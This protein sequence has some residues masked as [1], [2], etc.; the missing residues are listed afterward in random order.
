MERTAIIHFT[1]DGRAEPQGRPRATKMGNNIKLY[2]PPKSKAYK[3]VVGLIAQS[4]MSRNQLEPYTGALK[5]TLGFCFKP[6]KSYTQKRLKS[7]QDGTELYTKKSDI[8]N[9]AKAVTDGMNQ[10]TYHD[11]AQIVA[12]ELTKQYA[13]DDYTVVTIEP[14]QEENTND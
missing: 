8:D 13:D 7:I 1:I 9:L 12:M 14:L 10:I 5:V 3:R 6:P 4:Y 2:D 11:D